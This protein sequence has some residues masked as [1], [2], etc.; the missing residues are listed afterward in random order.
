[1]IVELELNEVDDCSELAA[2]KKHLSSSKHQF[3]H[4]LGEGIN[5]GATE[6]I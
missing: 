2:T 6:K 1:M 4:A 3:T 5:P